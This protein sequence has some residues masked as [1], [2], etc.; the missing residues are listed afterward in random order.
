MTPNDSPDMSK[1]KIAELANKGLP[2]NTAIPNTWPGIIAFLFLKLGGTAA[3]F[4]IAAVVFGYATKGIYEDQRE[5][6]AQLMEAFQNNTSVIKGFDKT[7]EGF[8]KTIQ[9]QTE[10]INNAHIRAGK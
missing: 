7:I 5:D 6:R 10:A 9:A 4:C 8:S 2:T 3:A 1:D